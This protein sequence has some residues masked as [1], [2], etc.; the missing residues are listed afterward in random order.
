MRTAARRIRSRL[1]D[2]VAAGD[3]AGAQVGP[4]V[5]TWMLA[6]TEPNARFPWQYFSLHSDGG[7]FVYH[8][9]EGCQPLQGCEQLMRAGWSVRN[10]H[11][12]IEESAGEHRSFEFRF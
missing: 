2:G 10:E 6:G 3:P 11:L 1:S 4:L 7:A 9:P 12:Y 8:L 5:G